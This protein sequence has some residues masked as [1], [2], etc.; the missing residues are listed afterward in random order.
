[1]TKDEKL[2][3][4]A[5]EQL[6]DEGYG[7]KKI[8]QKQQKIYRFVK[9]SNTYLIKIVIRNYSEGE[10]RSTSIPPH[11][12]E[13]LI[14]LSKDEK[15]V[16]LCCSIGHIKSD[17]GAHFCLFDPNKV[18]EGKFFPKDDK[19]E[20]Y[21]INIDKL[22]ELAKSEESVGYKFIK[23]INLIDKPLVSD[24]DVPT[25]IDITT[26]RIIRDTALST[27]IK[28]DNNYQCKICGIALD[29]PNGRK[30]TEAHHI[31]P[32]GKPHNGPDIEG[33]IICVCPN[34]HAQ[35]DYG[36]IKLELNSDIHIMQEYID[37]HNN[38]VYK[39]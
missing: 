32:L 33:N 13:K 10:S 1:M 24:L 5:I 22:P 25:K 37:Y 9:K 21:R 15:A 29:M 7:Y 14:Q 18:I 27:K 26:S 31:R 3:Q 4:L 39:P 35:L 23:D 17:K 20:K 19:G 28:E 30:Y 11:R 36:A 6:G 34:H 12:L 16:P 2:T 8:I 38:K